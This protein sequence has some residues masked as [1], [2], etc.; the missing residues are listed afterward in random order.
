[1]DHDL[2]GLAIE[3]RLPHTEKA[4]DGFFVAS[5]FIEL[6]AEAF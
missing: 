5:T 1:M 6:G 2:F 4:V 3:A